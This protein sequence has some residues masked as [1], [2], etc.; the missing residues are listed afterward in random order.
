MHE[1]MYFTTFLHAYLCRS[2]SIA[3][4]TFSLSMPHRHILIFLQLL[5]SIPIISTMLIL[6]HYTSSITISYL[7]FIII[8]LA[9]PL[10]FSHH[11]SNYSYPYSLQCNIVDVP[12]YGVLGGTLTVPYNMAGM[13]S[14]DVAVSQ[15]IPIKG[16]GHC[17]YKCTT[18]SAGND[19][20]VRIYTHLWI[21]WNRKWQLRWHACY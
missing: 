3:F 5:T 8:P 17:P 7:P 10:F 11:L 15:S 12:I 21:S 14:R 2:S 4:T 16:T 9:W 19:W 20:C 6:P 1:F 13:S 18:W